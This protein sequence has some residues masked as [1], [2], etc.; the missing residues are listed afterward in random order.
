MRWLKRTDMQDRN[1]AMDHKVQEDGLWF[2]DYQPTELERQ[3]SAAIVETFKAQDLRAQRFAMRELEKREI[4][5][6]WFNDEISADEY[7]QRRQAIYRK[8]PL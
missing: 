8:Y 5:H 1:E 6:L 7:Y 4:D 2:A 3:E